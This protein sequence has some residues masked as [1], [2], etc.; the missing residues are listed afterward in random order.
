MVSPYEGTASPSVQNVPSWPL[1][2]AGEGAL[3]GFAFPGAARHPEFRGAA[4]A[5]LA[6]LFGPEAASPLDVLI[7]DWSTDPETATERDQTPPAGHPTYGA[8]KGTT[9]VILSGSE[10]APMNGG[11]LEGAL[12]AAETARALLARVAA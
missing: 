7:K 4:I 10:T 6:R 11:F 9:R 2:G 1:K 3:F 5:Q 8:Q 12:E